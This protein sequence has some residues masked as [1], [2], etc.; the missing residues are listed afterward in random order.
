[1]TKPPEPVLAVI[2]P[3]ASKYEIKASLMYTGSRRRKVVAALREAYVKL[4]DIAEPEQI[5]AWMNR[6]ISTVYLGLKNQQL[7]EAGRAKRARGAKVVQLSLWRGQV[8]A[9]V[10]RLT[11]AEIATDVARRHGLTLADIRGRSQRRHVC[12][13]RD[14]AIYMMLQQPHLN[15]SQI[16][17]WLGGRDPSTVCQL[18]DNHEARMGELEAA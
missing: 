14:H 2:R 8:E 17:R 6:D 15:K 18:A 7:I 5:A 11:M 12:Q 1:M 9:S 13:A 16:A 3:I 4:R 10:G